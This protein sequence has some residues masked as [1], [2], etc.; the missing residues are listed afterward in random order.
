MNSFRNLW[1]LASLAMANTINSAR[2]VVPLVAKEHLEEDD[3]VEKLCDEFWEWRMKESPEFASYCGD[4][5]Y[6]DLLDDIDTDAFKGFE[7]DVKEMAKKAEEIEWNKLSKSGKANLYL[8]KD[9]FDTFIDGMEHKGWY[10]PINFM[11]GLHADIPKVISTCPRQSEE[12]FV[13]FNKRLECYAKKAQQVIQ[14]LREALENGYAFHMYS[15]EMVPEQIQEMITE[16][17]TPDK[18]V[19]LTPYLDATPDIVDPETSEKLL[20]EAKEIILTKVR[21]AFKELAEYI[22]KEYLPN[23]REDVAHTSLPDGE[24]LYQS[25]LDFHLSTSMTAKEVFELGLEEVDR[26]EKA[27]KR[28]TKEEGY[29]DDIQKFKE[30]ISKKEEFH[31]KTGEELLEYVNDICFKKIQPKLKKIFKFFPESPLIIEEVPPIMD[32]GDTAFYFN[33]SPD[34][35]R[36][37][38]YYIGTSHLD[39][40]PK[41]E[42]MALSLH[43]GEPGHHFQGM[44]AMESEDIHPFRRCLCDINYSRSPSRFPMNTAFLEG[45]GLYSEFLGEELDLYE[46]N[47]SLFGRYCMEMLRAVRLV[48]DP[49]IHAFGWSFDQALDFMIEKTFMDP[50]MLEVECKRYVTFPGQACAYKVGELK[51]KQLRKK[52]KS[53]LGDKFDIKDFHDVV[54]QCGAVPLKFLEYEVNEYIKEELETLMTLESLED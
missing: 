33:G 49:G 4:Q 43:E 53:A 30:D 28:V 46:D 19:F 1:R 34:G 3:K 11:D 48:V 20:E 6:C 36:P 42:I 40:I 23:T 8:L 16:E 14:I 17:L 47:Y 15:V 9:Q 26:I 50:K 25:C 21:P 29:G 37:G 35:S 51:L 24:A 41:Y 12:D 2:T 13:K 7:E 38:V 27:M 18:D 54:L 22:E 45:W 44:Y 5:R 32:T 39:A 10:F 52:A 31:F